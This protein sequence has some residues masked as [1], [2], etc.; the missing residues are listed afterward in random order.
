MGILA[1]GLIGKSEIKLVIGPAA[2]MTSLDMNG[3]SL[4][5]LRLTDEFSR[6]LQAVTPVSY[7]PHAIA[8]SFPDPIEAP[9]VSINKYIPS[10]DAI[11]SGA[12]EA[13]CS[14]LI[15]AKEELNALDAKVGDADC[16][17]TM[18][19]A[20]RRVL[21]KVHVLPLANPKQLSASL[22]E[23]LGDTMGGSSGILLSIMFLGMANALE[24]SSSWK[25][26]G[27]KA[28]RQGLQEM[29]DAGGAKPGMRTMLDAL[30]P[31]ADV[32]VEGKGFAAAHAAA[33]IGAN[34]TKTM[35]ARAGRAENV[36]DNVLQGIPDPGAV[37]VAKVFAA[38][39]SDL[40]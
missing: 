10:E 9:D 14:A 3:F 12:I 40:R 37:A 5:L 24:P 19:N 32:L 4:S 8:P 20:G 25:S 30:V 35:K 1:K 33:E 26:E 6:M 15:V 39:A 29:M 7:W 11:V 27:A 38:L 16:G 18:E 21:D 2:L 13:V 34:S 31:A 23:I 22:S 36:P 28:F 17:S